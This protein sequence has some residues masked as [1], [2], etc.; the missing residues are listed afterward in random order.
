LRT[1]RHDD[2]RL[3]FE[4]NSTIAINKTFYYI[5]FQYFIDINY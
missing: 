5:V 2:A 1:F 3:P 4:I